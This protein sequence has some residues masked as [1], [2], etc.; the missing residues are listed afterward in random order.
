MNLAYALIVIGWVFWS[1]GSVLDQSA[2]YVP[3]VVFFTAGALSAVA[4]TT[5]IR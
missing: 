4:S 5:R 2:L 1:I 3:A